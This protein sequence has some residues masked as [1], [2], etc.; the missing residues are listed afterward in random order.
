MFPALNFRWLIY[1]IIIRDLVQFIN[2][3]EKEIEELNTPTS[4]EDIFPKK[5]RKMISKNAFVLR[6]FSL[7]CG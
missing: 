2:H 7:L 6:Y 4:R 1:G 5:I 3:P